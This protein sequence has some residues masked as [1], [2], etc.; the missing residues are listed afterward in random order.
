MGGLASDSAAIAANQLVGS[1]V[2][3]TTN[4][5]TTTTP[6]AT[7]DV[8]GGV[9]Q[10]NLAAGTGSTTSLTVANNA[11]GIQTFT[12][13]N[14]YTGTTTINSGTL[15]IGN[16]TA[17]GT[18]GNAGAVTVASGAF[19]TFDRS[20]TAYTTNERALRELLAPSF[21]LGT[22]KTTRSGKP[23]APRPASPTRSAQGPWRPEWTPRS[24][25][26]APLELR[27]RQRGHHRGH[28][29]FDQW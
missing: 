3:S 16:A 23:P 27:R 5:L 13:T 10:N 2:S 20:D 7:N 26:R 9:L 18:L 4:T 15:Q 25:P 21:N 11:T 24:I 6:A 29:G 1:S 19:L 17:S 22:G 8:F 12:G 28:F 14:T